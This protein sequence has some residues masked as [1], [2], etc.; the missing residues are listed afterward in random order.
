MESASQG[1]RPTPNSIDLRNCCNMEIEVRDK[2]LSSK[3]VLLRNFFSFYIKQVIMVNQKLNV[4]YLTKLKQ[5]YM[6]LRESD[7]ISVTELQET[8]DEMEV[9]ETS[10]S[11]I[12]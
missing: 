6:K 12:F 1:E 2:I 7:K 5:E 8:I 3:R 11:H 9:D 4:S 10:K